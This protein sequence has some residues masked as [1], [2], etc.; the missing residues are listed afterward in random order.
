MVIMLLGG[1]AIFI[2]GMKQMSEGLQ[3]V[4]G[5]KLRWILRMFTKN[6]FIA[7]TI[8][9]LVTALIQSSS[10]CTV[11]TVGFVNAG[12]ITLRQAIGV[13]LGSNIGTTVTGQI[14]SFKLNNLAYPAIVIG[15]VVMMVIRNRTQKFWGQAIMGF[16]LLFLGMTIMSD[17]LKPLRYCPS[18][19]AF[20]Q[21]FNCAP[22]AG[23]MPLRSVLYSMFIGTA[24]TVVLQSSSATIGLTIALAGSGLI[25]FYTAVPIVLGDNIGTT[26]TAILASIGANRAAR[27]TAL[28]HSLFNIF[29]AAYM[30]ILFYVPAFWAKTGQP[31]FLQFVEDVTGG[32][33]FAASPENV[34]RHIAMAHSIFNIF[35]VLL[36]IP[37]VGVLERACTAI[38]PRLKEEEKL[39][40]LEPHLLS[41]PSIALEQAVNQ[42]GYMSGLS[43]S[44]ISE[45]FAT[46]ETFDSRREEKLRKRE[47][48]IDALQADITEYLVKLSQSHLSE[49]E[50]KMLAPLMH[51]VNDVERIGDHAE[52]ILEL[53]QLKND[54]KLTFT[55]TALKELRQMFETVREQFQN[56]VGAIEK[57]D[58][59]LADKALKLEEVINQLDRDLHNGHVQRLEAGECDTQAG[60]IFLD[61]VA[62]FEKVGDHLTNVAERIRLV[63]RLAKQGT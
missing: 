16:G 32:N 38:L 9:A 60:V 54:K 15:L 39:E 58:T 4:A 11:M 33:V 50:S 47:D 5:E 25:N 27:R 1:L 40:Y 10:A 55:D 19:V 22:V 36:F 48:D 6:R 21:G 13:V 35:N 42:L 14:I 43:F 18:F 26:I 62:N 28:A 46:L 17:T 51:A 20:F 53:A 52:N 49:E 41:Q 30:I 3:R 8:G 12:L 45:A 63:I 24:M 56:V 37:M 34:G 31:I 7:I 61:L 2:F 29:G 57:R 23:V 44:A 59:S